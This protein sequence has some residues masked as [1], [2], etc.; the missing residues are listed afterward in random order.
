MMKKRAHVLHNALDGCVNRKDFSVIRKYLPPKNEYVLSI[1][2]SE[3]QINLYRSY[4]VNH[5]GI[6]N[7]SNLGKVG[8]TQLF[9]DFQM[10]SRIWTHPWILKMNETRVQNNELKIAERNFV[11]DGD[12]EDEEDDDIEEIE[13]LDE[14]DEKSEKSE[15]ASTISDDDIIVED[16]HDAANKKNESRKIK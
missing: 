4:L 3:K 6:E 9:A 5:R 7:I 10:L 13:Y 1:R 2:L 12:E 11:V 8:G 15:K 14:D 16:S